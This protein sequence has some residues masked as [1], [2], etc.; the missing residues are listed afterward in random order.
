M[1]NIRRVARVFSE[2]NGITRFH[3]LYGDCLIAGG[4]E[5]CDQIADDDAALP[6]PLRI[7]RARQLWAA[8]RESLLGE[9]GTI[10]EDHQ[11]PWFP[12]FA[13]CL[14]DGAPLPEPHVFWGERAKVLHSH[15]AAALYQ[16]H[17]RA[18]R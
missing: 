13:Q 15:V 9:W 14:I 6:R 18:P 5:V 2:I 12:P 8:N 4:C 10:L 11:A 17:I 1:P 16:E 3:L 7:A